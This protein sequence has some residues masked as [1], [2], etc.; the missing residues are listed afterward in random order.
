MD[1]LPVDIATCECLRLGTDEIVVLMGAEQS[2]GALL[3][4]Q[5]RMPPGGGPPVM[6]RHAPSEIYSVISGE[7]V[8][9]VGDDPVERVVAGPG[10]VVPLAGWTPH[11]IR[12]E[13][14][15]DAVAFGVHAPAGPMEAFTR[16]AH[17]LAAG[18]E[19]RMEDVLAIAVKHGIEMLGP[20]PT[21]V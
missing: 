12:N 14:D 13:S 18:G 2:G 8:F 1:K 21:T 7:L 6:H 5:L 16:E 11:T 10:D 19:P 9:Y 15:V 4:V 20:V 17:A 3:A